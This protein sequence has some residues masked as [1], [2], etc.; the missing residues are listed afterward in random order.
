MQ[1]GIERLPLA[2]N[3]HAVDEVNPAAITAAGHDAGDQR[4]GDVILARP[5]QHIP[6]G[7]LALVQPLSALSDDRPQRTS[8]GCLTAAG[9]TGQNM[10][11]AL[12]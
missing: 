12:S 4:V 10:K 3:G 11:L 9:I 7:G 5:Y 8:G 1:G 6:C 2:V